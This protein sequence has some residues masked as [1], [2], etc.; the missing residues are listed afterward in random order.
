MQVFLLFISYA[1]LIC[2]K[3]T[4]SGQK[5]TFAFFFILEQQEKLD[6]RNK[7]LNRPSS[8]NLDFGQ[9]ILDNVDWEINY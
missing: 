9:H 2:P 7:L 3:H 5:V 8:Y 6:G 1:G 4:T